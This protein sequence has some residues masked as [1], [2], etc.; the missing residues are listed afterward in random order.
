MKCQPL[1]TRVLRRRRRN[2]AETT[3]FFP[4]NYQSHPMIYLIRGA[5]P[6]GFEK[7]IHFCVY[8]AGCASQ[9]FSVV[10]MLLPSLCPLECR[11]G[12]SYEADAN[13]KDECIRSDTILSTPRSRGSSSPRIIHRYFTYCWR[14]VCKKSQFF[15]ELFPFCCWPVLFSVYGMPHFQ[16]PFKSGSGFAL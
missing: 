8:T 12:H 6:A 7:I 14:G 1:H 10:L 5:A 11:L 3:V 15:A 16:Q 2:L 4:G 9:S 13:S